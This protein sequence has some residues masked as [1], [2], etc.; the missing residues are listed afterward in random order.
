MVENKDKPIAKPNS[1]LHQVVFAISKAGRI[2][3]SIV[4]KVKLLFLR[5]IIPK[6]MFIGSREKQDKWMNKYGLDN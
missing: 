3:V 2:K 4:D 1:E 5:M 6:Q